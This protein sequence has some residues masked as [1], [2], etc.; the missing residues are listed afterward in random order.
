[1]N[2]I[3]Y[4]VKRNVVGEWLKENIVWKLMKQFKFK[5]E[6]NL[7]LLENCFNNFAS[8]I[9]GKKCKN[10][11]EKKKMV[12]SIFSSRTMTYTHR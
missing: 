8:K 11:N 2:L 1:M 3:C 5:L 12:I 9:M 10:S 6:T 4:N 7:Q